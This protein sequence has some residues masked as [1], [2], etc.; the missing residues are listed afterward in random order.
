MNVEMLNEIKNLV[1]ETANNAGVNLREHFKT[2][3]EFK[4][5]IIAM[6]FE[7][8]TNELGYSVEDATNAVLGDDAYQT[9]YNTV[10]A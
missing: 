6:T 5:F 2:Q 3:D 9:I 7:K 1:I 10:A 4:N 8:L